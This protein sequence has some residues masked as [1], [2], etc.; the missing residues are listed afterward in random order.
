MSLIRTL[1][2]SGLKVDHDFDISERI[3]FY[4]RLCQEADAVLFND[5]S[6]VYELI[7]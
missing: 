2:E 6:E 1:H 5:F 7:K 4:V 3:N